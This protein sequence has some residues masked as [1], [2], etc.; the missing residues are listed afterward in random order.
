MQGLSLC[1]NVRVLSLFIARVKQERQLK[2]DISEKLRVLR[3]LLI[4]RK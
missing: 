4:Q 3:A 1:P 2:K